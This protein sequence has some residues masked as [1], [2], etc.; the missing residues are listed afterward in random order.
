M[1]VIL[2]LSGL[3][4]LALFAELFRFRKI[5]YPLVIIGLLGAIAMA[6]SYWNF[7][8]G[9][10][11]PY[12]N[13]MVGTIKN[14]A[15]GEIVSN[16]TIPGTAEMGPGH[17]FFQ[18]LSFGRPAV[19]LSI[20]MLATALLWFI[21]AKGFFKDDNNST[22][23]YALIIFALTGG[24]ILTCY[25][26]MVML[27]LGVEILSIPLYVL[28][29]SRK[30]D[31]NSN[32]SAFKYFVMGAFASGF[33]LLGITL[34]YGATASFDLHA[35]AQHIQTHNTG[36]HT[37][38]YAGI[39][40]LLV[41]LLFKI[42]AAPFHFW[43]PDVYEGAPVNI[44]AFMS[45]VV[46]TAAIAAIMPLFFMVFAGSKEFWTP[47]IAVCVGLTFVIGNITAA[48]Q[49]TV[50]RMMAFSSIS[51]AGFLLL[52]IVAASS[53]FS[54]KAI[55]YY[56]AAYSVASIAV[57]TVLQNIMQ[58]TGSD[59]V[60]NFSGLGKKNP[61]MAVVMTIALLSLAGI[62]PTAGFFGKYYVFNAALTDGHFWLVGIGILTSLVGV[63]YYFRLIIAMYFKPANDDRPIV[64]SAQ[65]QA[66]LFITAVIIL[67]LGLLPDLILEIGTLT[68]NAEAVPVP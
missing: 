51:H 38:L 1:K 27:F 25:S 22:D 6:V 23:H 17:A 18:M 67:V 34:I 32:E 37:F 60:E 50:K 5:L 16:H 40:M 44:T 56:A 57:F 65:H 43:T 21:M 62:P 12:F 59:A 10:L 11:T 19:M 53:G 4:L 48:V 39:L 58:Q 36:S 13:G 2:L 63:Y 64:A 15:T 28:A 35:I 14:P 29:G 24:I 30:S 68:S 42:G 61:L 49:N 3:G 45:T 55:I 31:P 9:N 66:L 41:G 20:V 7:D 26:S 8:D 52:A 46:K 33:L 54:A 47:V